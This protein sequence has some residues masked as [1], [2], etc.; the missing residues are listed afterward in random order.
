MYPNSGK[1]GKKGITAVIFWHTMLATQ[2][3]LGI[4]TRVGGLWHGG[5]PFQRLR[6]ASELCPGRLAE[7]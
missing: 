2:N 1:N 5:V 7:A 4:H 3:I 6:F